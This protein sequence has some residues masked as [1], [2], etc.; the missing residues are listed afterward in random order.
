MSVV[1]A[2]HSVGEHSSIMCWAKMSYFRWVH[3]AVTLHPGLHTYSNMAS[4]SSGSRH[5]QGVC[6]H[7]FWQ[8]TPTVS[9]SKEQDSTSRPKL[10]IISRHAVQQLLHTTATVDTLGRATELVWLNDANMCRCR[11]TVS[12]TQLC[13][14]CLPL[15]VTYCS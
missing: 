15:W 9:T 12:T 3:Q 4:A 7:Q 11:S 6:Q 2:G 10:T 1:N 5:E 14:L 8:A 13:D